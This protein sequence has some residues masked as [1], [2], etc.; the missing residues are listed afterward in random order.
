RRLRRAER[1]ATQTGRNGSWL[2]YLLSWMGDLSTDAAAAVARR[3]NLSTAPAKAVRGWPMARKSLGESA[4]LGAARLAERIEALEV[5]FLRGVGAAVARRLRTDDALLRPDGRV[6]DLG[7]TR[8]GGSPQDRLSRGA[9]VLLLV[10][11]SPRVLGVAG[12]SVE[13]PQKRVRGKVF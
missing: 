12:R 9:R 5:D 7:C 6:E 4:D 13:R 1:L 2:V 11:L 3:L 10:L 8:G